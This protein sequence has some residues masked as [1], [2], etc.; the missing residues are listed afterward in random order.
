MYD[1]RNYSDGPFETF[2]FELQSFDS[3]NK[4]D[5]ENFCCL[6]MECSLDDNHLSVSIVNDTTCLIHTIDSFSVKI[7]YCFNFELF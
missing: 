6:S 3:E 7:G 4:E 2:K 1:I 5:N